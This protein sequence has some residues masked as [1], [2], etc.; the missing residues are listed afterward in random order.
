VLALA[1]ALSSGLGT[2]GSATASGVAEE[3]DYELLEFAASALEAGDLKRALKAYERAAGVPELRSAALQ[4]I[5]KAQMKL[6]RPEKALATA[7]SLVAAAAGSPGEEA[8]GIDLIGV[9]QADLALEVLTEV[10]RLSQRPG[11][12]KPTYRQQVEEHLALSESSHRRA[13]ELTDGAL[14]S[15]WSNLVRLLTDTGRYLEARDE[16]V[17]YFEHDPEGRE[18]AA[19]LLARLECV[20][21]VADLA[22]IV[23]PG[24]EGVEAATKV[25]HPSPRLPGDDDPGVAWATGVVDLEGRYRCVRIVNAGDFTAEIEELF[26]SALATWRFEPAT[27]E[28]R[29]V[30]AFHGDSVEAFDRR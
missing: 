21:D 12:K 22:D 30:A 23:R 13:L 15:A 8:V 29:R 19:E 11:K 18:S 4:G 6:G 24:D 16:L 3:P 5:A 14:P 10:E 28:G 25:F 17:L 1:A 20:G 26:L 7:E 2:L 9:V 27:R